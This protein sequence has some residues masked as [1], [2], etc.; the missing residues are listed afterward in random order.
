MRRVKKMRERADVEPVAESMPNF[1]GVVRYDWHG[2]ITYRQGLASRIQAVD[3]WDWS[4]I[5]MFR[6]IVVS[7]AT[8]LGMSG[9]GGPVFHPWLARRMAPCRLET[10]SP[11]RHV[12]ASV[13]RFRFVGTR[14]EPRTS[15][16]WCQSLSAWSH[17]WNDRDGF[18]EPCPGVTG[19]RG[20]GG[21]ST[22][23]MFQRRLSEVS[24]RSSN[25]D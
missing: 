23:R 16:P 7:D 9:R 24:C 4:S 1:L 3:F 2:S 12:E 10:A 14:Q 8:P 17:T 25:H 22:H 13:C 20:G 18:K 6:P 21:T 11:Y 15:I 19:L 5:R